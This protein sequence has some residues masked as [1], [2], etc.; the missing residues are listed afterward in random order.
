MAADLVDLPGP[1]GS[2]SFGTAVA[3]LPNGNFVVTD[4]GYDIPGGAGNVGAVYLFNPLGGQISRLTGSTSGDAVGSGGI[5]IVGSGNFV[6]RSPDW[7]NGPSA[8]DAGAVTWGSGTAGVSGT[9][10]AG[11]SLVGT[12]ANDSVGSAG[13]TLGGITVLANGHYVVSSPDWGNGSDN[14][15]GAVTWGNGNSGVSGEVSAANS[16][17]GSVLNDQIGRNRVEPLANGSYIVRSPQWDHGALADAGAVTWGSG[18][19]GTAGV[20]GPANSLV[21]GS[22]NDQVGFDDGYRGGTTAL[23]NGNYVVWSPLWDNGTAADAGA[24]TWG[25]GTTGISGVISSANS[26][27]GVTAGDFFSWVEVTELTNGHYVLSLPGWNNGS[28]SDAGAAMWCNGSTGRTG[29]VSSANALVGTASNA[30]VAYLDAVTPLANGHYVVASDYWHNG[31][32]LNAGAVT[33]CNGDTG[34]TG[35]ISAAN[36]LVGTESLNN[37]GSGGVLALPNGHYVVCSPYAKIG[38]LAQAGA[39]TWCNGTTGRSGTLSSANSLVGAQAGDQ[40]GLDGATLLANGNYVVTSFFADNGTL[41]HAGAVTWCDGST[42]R[43]GAISTANSLM[44]GQAD[45]RVG[46]GEVTPLANGHYVVR[47]STWKN[48]SGAAVGAVTWCNGSTGRAGIV[49]AANSLTGSTASDN[50][51]YPG[52][53]ALPN[54]N[55]VVPTWYWDNG[56]ATDAGAVTWC[57]GGSGTTGV[58]SAANSLVGTTASDQIGYGGLRVLADGNYVVRSYLWDNAGVSNA[59]AVTRCSGTAGLTGE[60]SAAN[61]LVGITA[62]DRVGEG[63]ELA[64]ADGSYLFSSPKWNQGAVADA[65]AV[66]LFQPGSSRAGEISGASGIVGTVATRGSSLSFGY[67]AVRGHMIVGRPYSNLV[68]IFSYGEIFSPADKFQAWAAAAGLEGSAAL[69]DEDP[70]SD[71]V[72]N[73]LKYAFNMNGYAADRRILEAGSGT[74][75]LPRFSLDGTGGLRVFRVEYL[76]RLDSGLSYQPMIGGDPG[77]FVPMTGMQAAEPAG[78]GWERVTVTQEVDVHQ[79]P[80]LFGIV[81]VL[82]P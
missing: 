16:I 29:I 54:G 30:L 61:S 69:A 73:L 47:S 39:A 4:P 62:S 81:E 22:A 14:R 79:V 27:T 23:A 58:I 59:G 77:S 32:A 65:G 37:I 3:V 63:P 7:Y 13:T 11:N 20:V 40:V 44:G 19:G 34:R 72:A 5:F 28:A 76:R 51:G 78:S 46:G 49:T 41:T 43:T 45:D 57:D 60:V 25:S 55:Y 31:T 15:A 6:I 26:V 68:S 10:S 52:V 67:D 75:G 2:G 70:F 71:G 21:G 82:L 56:T 18:T 17:V 24:V 9:V 8:H 66:M 50:T 42:G 38:T 74:A 33:W 53:I 35:T 36:S 48:P 64:A 80:R 12:K 1:P